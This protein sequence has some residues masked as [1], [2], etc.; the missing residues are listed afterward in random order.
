M[1]KVVGHIYKCE[2]IDIAKIRQNLI[3][4]TAYQYGRIWDRE[5]FKCVDN[6]TTILKK[7][8]D[9]CL[10]YDVLKKLVRGFGCKNRK[11]FESV[12]ECMYMLLG[13]FKKNGVIFD[14]FG[15]PTIFVDDRS[16][17]LN[18]FENC[19]FLDSFI[20]CKRL[21]SIFKLYYLI[22]YSDINNDVKQRIYIIN[23]DECVKCYE[24]KNCFGKNTI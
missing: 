15:T 10:K 17:A 8:R 23:S 2:K 13:K 9:Y 12:D 20:T 4:Q 3:L 18:R 21:S 1:V 22:D 19:I 11:Y 7:V 5:E 24:K 16:R 6:G 14:I